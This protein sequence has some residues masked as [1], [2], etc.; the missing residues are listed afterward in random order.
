[1]QFYKESI[2]KY[3]NWI[4]E[5][6]IN[7]VKIHNYL[8][9]FE[10]PEESI[11]KTV[12]IL[13]DSLQLAMNKYEN[14]PE[15]NSDDY[16]TDPLSLFG[17]S[18]AGRQKVN[19][20]DLQIS[21]GLLKY[22]RQSFVDLLLH[23]NNE[24]YAEENIRLF[25]N[26]CFDKIEI[27]F[28]RE[29]N[30]I[31]Q[32]KKIQKMQNTAKFLTKEKNKLIALL[33]SIEDPIL[34]LDKHNNISYSNK[35]AANLLKENILPARLFA[36]NEIFQI[37]GWLLEEVKKYRE[38]VSGEDSFQKEIKVFNVVKHY[39][40]K[41]KHMNMLD[42]GKDEIYIIFSDITSVKRAE[43]HL[44][45]YRQIIEQ[46]PVSIMITNTKGDI[47]YVNPRFTDLTGYE[48]DEVFNRNPRIFKSANVS[49]DYRL[50]WETINSG[51]E[52]KG[53]FQNIKKDGTLIYEL[54]TISTMVDSEGNIINFIAWQEDISDQ[55]K[56]EDAVA[57]SEMQFRS[58]WDHSFNGMRLTDQDGIIVRV[59]EAFCKMVE[60]EKNLL[61][62]M[63]ISLTYFT[64]NRAA[65]IE[66]Y[67]LHF[68]SNTIESSFEKEML[69]WN[70]KAKWLEVTNSI[71]RLANNRTLVLSVFK[72]I[73]ENK[74]A[75]QFIIRSQDK[76]RESEKKYRQ[77]VENS[78]EGIWVT[79]KDSRTTY[80]NHSMC[81]LLDYH[82]DEMIGR[83]I[84]DFV[85]RDDIGLVKDKNEKRQSKISDQYELRL[86]KRDGTII[87]V[88]ISASPILDEMDN[89]NGTLGIVS[90]ITS[91][92][93]IE[94]TLKYERHLFMSLMD[95]IPDFIYFKD[96][97]S[98]FTRINMSLAKRFGL[99]HPKEAIGKTDFDFFDVKPAESFRN[100]ETR[101]MT[102]G[103]GMFNVDEMNASRA[104]K[105]S[106]FVTTKIPLKDQTGKIIGV[107]GI[108]RDITDRKLMEKVLWN[109]K[110]ELNVTLRSV[111]EGVITTNKDERI[112]LLNKKAEEIT[113]YAQD[114]VL[115][116]NL[117]EVFLIIERRAGN[118]FVNPIKNM[119]RS[120]NLESLEGQSVLIS[121]NN[122]EK[123][124]SYNV[125]AIKDR[126]NNYTGFVLVF[127]DISEKIKL[128]SQTALSQKMESI[129]QLAAGISHEINTPMQYIGDNTRFLKDSFEDIREILDCAEH[130]LNAENQ[131][132]NIEQCIL[133]LKNIR[134][135]I[136]LEYLKLEIPNA[137]DQ[138]LTGIDRV[139]QIVLAMKDFA[140]PGVKSKALSDLNHGIE[141]TATISRNEWKYVADLETI[142]DPTL[143]LVY[144]SMDE[145]NQVILNMI[146]NSAHSIRDIIDK[147]KIEKGK[148]TI[149]TKNEN[150]F[151]CVSISDTGMGIPKEIINKVF[152]PFFTTKEVGEGTG[153]GLAIAH[154]IIVNKH[155]G[156]IEVESAIE[157]GTTFIIKIPIMD[158]QNGKGK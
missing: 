90:D 116:K 64:D 74:L 73:T 93:L 68:N 70:G 109:E 148:I 49:V 3:E 150:N 157:K 158:E 23:V 92:K 125:S 71:L 138:S 118:S 153:Q 103:L 72:D 141:V 14:P 108:S 42:E 75:E 5:K 133:Q 51:R 120:H 4:T 84:L 121:K 113:G 11:R 107:F 117:T 34:L 97:E 12:R 96:L 119:M 8:K 129:G 41:M 112:V 101:I 124:V 82:F 102:S 127:K 31:Y 106:W 86:K 104:G 32:D 145:I 69:L 53:I 55:K 111:G 146:V 76:L 36:G 151:A 87:T 132:F 98:R 25:I 140:H 81:R 9:Y 16:S 128:E 58:V 136:D 149:K 115:N 57:E 35:E 1:M 26:R 142:L 123:M 40:I 122:C 27:G 88:N 131:E 18:E 33:E 20:T 156:S 105:V 95:N 130:L 66:R 2:S 21:L 48:F 54:T 94:N 154:D 144:C 67:K 56:A 38:G 19:N 7:Y 110:E 62:G 29:W 17:A 15:L 63:P 60:M 155:K 59:N 85:Y 13:S 99:R 134:K 78:H 147:G 135:N 22:Y 47:E 126:E 91:K 39:L 100:D 61:E 143:P 45:R 10:N 37:S 139:R 79:D 114:E 46:S 152:D 50:L 80:M 6:I 77:L 30:S 43:E 28:C 44:R 137:I 83:V 52:W 65:I 24:N 89:Y